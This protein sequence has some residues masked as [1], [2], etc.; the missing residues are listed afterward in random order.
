MEHY[1]LIIAYDGTEYRGFQ[2]QKKSSTI[3]GELESALRK[4]GWQGETIQAAGRTDTG[5]HAT[6]QVVTFFHDWAHSLIELKAALNSHLPPSIAVQSVSL[7]AEDFHPR[8]DAV[9]REYKYAITIS[10][11]RQPQKERYMWRINKEL[12]WQKINEVA[13]LFIGKYDFSQFGRAL[14]DDGSTVREVLISK[15]EQITPTDHEYTICADAFLYHMVRRIVSVMVKVGENRI[16]E[17]EIRKALNGHP[18][19]IAPG[20]A[21]ACG[22]TLIKVRYNDNK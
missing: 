16:D 6:G 9:N 22:L 12:D 19:K 2:R 4:I 5:V 7:A 8:Y 17:Q 10:D 3:Q 20:I 15:W 13:D 1:Q 14:K 18:L 11:T 21:P